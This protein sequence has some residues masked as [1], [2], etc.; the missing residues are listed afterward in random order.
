M[1]NK[2]DTPWEETDWFKSATEQYEISMVRPP[3]G[4]KQKDKCT[5]DVGSFGSG[6]F[7]V[8]VPDFDPQT[9]DVIRPLGPTDDRPE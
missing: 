4:E 1:M 9:E 7:L 8:H 5:V 2:E 3:S 6:S